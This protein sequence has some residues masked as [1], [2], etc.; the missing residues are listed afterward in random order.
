M[1]RLRTDRLFSGFLAVCCGWLFHEKHLELGFPGTGKGRARV[2][3]GSQ[4]IHRPSF[5]PRQRSSLAWSC[6]RF[7]VLSVAWLSDVPGKIVR[8]CN[9]IARNR[10]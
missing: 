10:T 7:K 5:V 9:G 6:R 4:V 2:W 8:V 1:L 3:L